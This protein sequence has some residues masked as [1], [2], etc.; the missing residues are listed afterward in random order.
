MKTNVSFHS[1]KITAHYLEIL[2]KIYDV[3][4]ASE[5]LITHVNL[6]ISR[7]IALQFRWKQLEQSNIKDFGKPSKPQQN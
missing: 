6:Q 2:N 3:G 1:V 5:A 7:M 4:L